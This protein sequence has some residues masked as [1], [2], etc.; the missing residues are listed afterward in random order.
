MKLLK[1]LTALSLAGVMTASSA[2]YAFADGPADQSLVDKQAR[3]KDNVLEYDEIYDLV[4]TYNTTVKSSNRSLSS[5][6]SSVMDTADYVMEKAEEM[7]DLADEIESQYDSQLGSGDYSQ[8]TALLAQAAGAKQQAL[9][10]KKQAQASTKSADYQIA[11]LNVE[12]GKYGIVMMAQIYMS[13]YNQLVNQLASTQN[14]AATAEAAYQAAQQQQ[15]LGMNTSQDVTSFQNQYQTALNAIKTIE[16]NLEN[17][18]DMLGQLCGWST[19]SI[20]DVR[21]IPAAD[22]SYIDGINLQND[23]KRAIGNSYELRIDRRSLNSIGT[24]AE[25]KSLR[26]SIADKEQSSNIIITQKYN[27]L[28]QKRATYDS[29]LVA[30]NLETANLATAQQKL[31]MGMI[32]PLE[33]TQAQYNYSVKEADL[34]NADIDLFMAIEDYKW[35]VEKGMYNTTSGGM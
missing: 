15:A 8:L 31:T 23:I 9:N 25:E 24:S 17:V 5:F 18:R 3:L 21:E 16:S 10:L 7:E 30:F 22:P 20:P 14:L 6:K 2:M 34:K 27:T 4:D 13:Q 19:G 12:Q 35:A 1:T 33:F 11:K 28:L 26:E 32:S 29:A